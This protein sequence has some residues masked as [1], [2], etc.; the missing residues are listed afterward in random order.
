MVCL[1]LL[2][3]CQ[4][5]AFSAEPSP[6]RTVTAT[7]T[8]SATKNE[9]LIST[10][11]PTTTQQPTHNIDLV[12]TDTPQA[13][14]EQVESPYLDVEIE[15]FDGF[16]IA[17]TIYQPGD[18]PSPW[19]VVV[20]LHM[21]WGDRNSWDEFA[22]QLSEAGFAVLAIDMRG[23]GDTGGSVDW[24]KAAEDLG[25]VW[26]FLESRDDFDVQRA[27]FVGASIG[28][29]MALKAGNALTAVDTVVLLSPGLNYAGVSTRRLIEEFGQ[30]PIMIAA[31][32]EDAYSAQSSQTLAQIAS[33]DIELVMYQGAGHGIQM[34]SREP[35]LAEKIITW[36]WQHLQ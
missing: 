20:L 16:R 12:V 17:G 10:N 33:G 1:V 2:S 14:S 26:N 11:T 28:A 6:T 27:A 13:A 18:T 15:G 3:G 21:L 9:V 36:L 7:S 4:P 22:K 29:N 5:A 24:D 31:S 25:Y 34:L 32:E 19:P 23:H 35:E 8:I 30:R